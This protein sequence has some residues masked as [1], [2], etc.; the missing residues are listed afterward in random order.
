[1]DAGFEFVG[2]GV[3]DHPM[4]GDPALPPERVRYNINSKVCF[5]ARS[6]SGV[7]FML[8]GFVDYLQSQRSEGLSQLP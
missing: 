3:V 8:M 7:T 2:K 5:S 4:T 1:M 6:M